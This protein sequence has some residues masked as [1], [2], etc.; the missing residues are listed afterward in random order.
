[1]KAIVKAPRAKN[2]YYVVCL[3]VALKPCKDQTSYPVY[4]RLSED[5]AS[6][7]EQESRY[8]WLMED[9]RLTRSKRVSLE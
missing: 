1:M 4:L 7:I 8:E 5:V 2:K 3:R 9:K 6:M